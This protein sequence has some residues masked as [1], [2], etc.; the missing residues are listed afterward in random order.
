MLQILGLREFYPVDKETGERSI[1]PKLYDAFLERGYRAPNIFDLFANMEKYVAQIPEEERWNMFY[2][3]ANC[4]SEKRQFES[5]D[6]IPIDIDGIEAGSEA[7]VVDVVCTELGL[8]PAKV[9]I[10]YSGNGVHILVGLNK[11][12]IEASFLRTQKAYYKAL[13]GRVNTAL[14][15]AG[16]KGSADTTVFSE[17][18]ILRLPFTKNVKKD[19]AVKDCV[20]INGN[21]EKQDKDLYALAD[22]PE[23]AEGEHIHPNA[24]RRMP[25]PDAEAI[26]QKCG[27]VN[28]CREHQGE[29]S[30]PMWYA[31]LSIVGRFENGDKLAHEYSKKHAGYDPV[32]TQTKIE[33]ALSA[34][35][36]RTCANI[37]TMYSGCAS[38]PHSQGIVSP[39]QL[40]GENTIRTQK[41]GFYNIKITATGEVTQGKPNYD[42]LEKWFRSKYKYITHR[43]TES[44]YVHKDTHWEEVHRLD[45]HGFAEDNFRPTPTNGMCLEFESKLKRK[46]NVS[47]E[48]FNVPNMLN[49]KNGVLDLDTG[50]INPH[51]D[52]YGFTYTI[53]YDFKPTGDCPVFKKFLKDV[54]MGDNALANLIVEY[55]GFCLSTAHPKLVQKCAIL[56]GDGSN[57]KSVLLDLMRS[58]VGAKNWS[59]VSVDGLVKETNRYQ[60]MHKMFN[61]SDETPKDAF[62]ESS[63]FKAIVS[64]DVVPVRRLYGDPFDWECTTKVMF[65][66]NDLPFSG[67]YSHGMFRRLLIIPFNNTFS[68]EL[69]NKDAMIGEKLKAEM[70]DIFLMCF[71][72]FK[73]LRKRHYKFEEVKAITEELED[74]TD[75]SDNV[76]RFFANMC[77]VKS[78][79]KVTTDMLFRLYCL[80]CQENSL[81]PVAFA[82][83]SRR[84]GKVVNRYG[85]TIEKTR[86]KSNHGIRHT[87]YNNL[88]VEASSPF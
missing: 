45:L 6:I 17:A 41:T 64:G 24:L 88:A 40:I 14:F 5:Q 52:E 11:P 31:M 44:V 32:K 42:D 9:G 84:F 29:L 23:V 20:L 82:S 7:V 73:N 51:N 25:T 68:D 36:P 12:I 21:I 61:V 47:K 59:S 16:V 76:K 2:T 22:M 15:H 65:A 1:T 71:E 78:G 43:E 75:S 39:I 46:N 35:G 48:F 58:M 85:G 57:G 34:S 30:E 83:F 28:H 81:K 13:A 3:V 18:R 56:Y 66:C 77:V 54:T 19:K 27:F 49:F 62:L 37:S 33:H 26:Q 80:Y 67:D 50:V 86:E 70:S 38:C 8:D 87:V 60:I 79:N 10:V 63:T 55:M 72:G 53:P 69:G 74:Y 4:T